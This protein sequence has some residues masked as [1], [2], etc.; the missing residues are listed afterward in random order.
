MLQAVLNKSMS[1]FLSMLVERIYNSFNFFSIYLLPLLKT[2]SKSMHPKQVQSKDEETDK[3]LVLKISKYTNNMQ[4][5]ARIYILLG[6]GVTSFCL[7]KFWLL[8]KNNFKEHRWTYKATLQNQLTLNYICNILYLIFLPCKGSNILE[9]IGKQS[10][11]L[12]GGQKKRQ[13]HV[14]NTWLGTKIPDIQAEWICLN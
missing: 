1:K 11:K 14:I 3:N 7:S 13:F 9:C 6:G 12:W 8:L 2:S 5:L 4:R 10:P